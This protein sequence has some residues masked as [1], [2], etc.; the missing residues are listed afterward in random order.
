MD[1]SRVSESLVTDLVTGVSKEL[2][3]RRIENVADRHSA[4]L[5][6]IPS[7]KTLLQR[8]EEMEVS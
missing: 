2:H 4:F 3:R 7:V 8:L 6:D 1:V 5:R